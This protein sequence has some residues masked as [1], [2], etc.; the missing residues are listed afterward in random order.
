MIEKVE[1]IQRLTHYLV[2][3]YGSENIIVTDYHDLDETAISLADK[4][5]EYCVYISNCNDR[6]D[7]YYVSLE[8]PSVSENLP[9]EQGDDF[10]DLTADEVEKILVKHL[11]I[12]NQV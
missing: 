6:D 11:K 3:K 7:D 10:G 1:H 5:K 12:S 8:N 2:N 4:T 9:Y